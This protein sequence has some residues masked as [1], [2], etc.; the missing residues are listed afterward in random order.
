MEKVTIL[1]T[2]D[3]TGFLLE[4]ELYLLLID[5]L[6]ATYLVIGDVIIH[7]TASSLGISTEDRSDK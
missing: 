5:G 1:L 3:F 4:F 2:V 6:M 7:F